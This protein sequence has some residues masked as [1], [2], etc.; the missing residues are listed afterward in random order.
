MISYAVAGQK[1][2]P[3]RDRSQSPRSCFRPCCHLSTPFARTPVVKS[4][5]DGFADRYASI[6]T[7]LLSTPT[8]F[9]QN[10]GWTK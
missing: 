3:R 6:L 8:D 2:H 5:T 10:L 4:P 9:R 1:R 7:D